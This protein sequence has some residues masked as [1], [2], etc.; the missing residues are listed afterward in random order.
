MRGYAA[1]HRVQNAAEPPRAVERRL[2]GAVTAALIQA[3]DNP[4]NLAVK[5][6]AILWNKRVWDS[7]IIEVT[8]EANRLPKE[9]KSLI[10]R[11][12]AWVTHE[13]QKVMDGTSTT[14]MLIEVNQQIIEGLAS[15]S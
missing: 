3:Q 12:G 5:F 2:M 15:V 6:D 7:F 11:L 9:T 13:T 8:D 14:D 4:A 1:Y 10:I